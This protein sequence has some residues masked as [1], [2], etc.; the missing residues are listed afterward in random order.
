MAS[1]HTD[2]VIVPRMVRAFVPI[3]QE[4]VRLAVIEPTGRAFGLGPLF[5]AP[6]AP[7]RCHVLRPGR[8]L[9]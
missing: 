3:P 9:R 8:R 2:R 6:V 4:E 7:Q 5:G 1:W